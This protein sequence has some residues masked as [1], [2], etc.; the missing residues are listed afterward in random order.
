M[1]EIIAK[2]VESSQAGDWQ[3][4]SDIIYSA[5]R[6]LV[7]EFSDLDDYEAILSADSAQVASIFD[8]YRDNQR[9]MSE[10]YGDTQEKQAFLMEQYEKIETPFTYEAYDSWDTM[11]YY[12]TTYRQPA[13]SLCFLPVASKTRAMSIAV[14]IPFILFCVS[15]FIGRASPFSLTPDQLTMALP[16]CRKRSGR[17]NT[18]HQI[19]SGGVYTA[20]KLSD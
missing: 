2:S 1:P 7:G 14:A 3:S 11:L 17:K 13:F 19:M 8:I 20:A 16:I 9:T 10:E 5:S 4:T 18:F 15:P 6:M 12:A